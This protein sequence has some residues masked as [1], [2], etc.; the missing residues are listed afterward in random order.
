VDYFEFSSTSPEGSDPEEG[1]SSFSIGKVPLSFSVDP[2]PEF[3]ETPGAG[4]GRYAGPL[5]YSLFIHSIILLF[6]LA[7]LYQP[8]RR[9]VKE[10]SHWVVNL[11]SAIKEGPKGPQAVLPEEPHAIAGPIQPIPKPEA[12]SSMGLKSTAEDGLLPLQE[13]SLNS[14]AVPESPSAEFSPPASPAEEKRAEEAVLAMQQSADQLSQTGQYV[15]R[16]RMG[17]RMI[18]MKIKYFQQTASAHL[19]G[20]IQ[21]AIPED[22][23]KTLQGKSTVVRILY[24]EDG[25]LQEILFDSGSEDPFIQILKDGIKWDALNAPRRYGLPFREMKVRIG[26]D[27]EGKPSSRITLL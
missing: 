19:S 7:V 2:P 5:L 4:R 10:V 21:S 9:P 1:I 17:D 20:L 11:V 13:S 8:D 12:P 18:G 27:A 24:Q 14:L 15:F 16:M 26:L 6:L 23:R 3:L 25:T 22:L